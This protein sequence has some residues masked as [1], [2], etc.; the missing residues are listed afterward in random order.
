MLTP[1]PTQISGARFL[2]QRRFALLADLPRVG[3]TGSAIIAADAAM[4][5]RICVVTTASGRGVWRRGFGDWSNYGRKLQVLTGGVKLHDDT[6]VVIVSWGGLCQAGIRS[7]LLHREWDLVIADEAH[8]AKSFTTKR[9]QALYGVIDADGGL[10]TTI[11]LLGRTERMWALTGT[12]LPNCPLDAYPMMRALCPV[13]LTGAWWGF[14]APGVLKFPDVSFLDDFTKRYCRMRPMQ[15]GRGFYAKRIDVFVEGLNLEEL[16]ARLAGFYLQ[17]TQQDV[18]ILEPE[19]E[20]MPLDGEAAGFQLSAAEFSVDRRQVLDAA[21]AGDTKSLNMHLGPLRRLTGEIKAH[22]VV[23][24][25]KEE[26][27]AGLDK[28]V[29]AYWHKDVGQIL[30]DG[31]HKFGV[32]GIDGATSARNRDAA[33]KHFRNDPKVR[34]FLG[35]IQAAGEAIDLS[36]A[37]HL[38]FVETSFT[39]KDML[40]M[41]LR[42]T[43]HTQTQRPLVR[44]AT[45]EGSIDDA[46]QQIL[47][48]K[49]TAIKEVL[50]K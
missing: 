4:A 13:R 12:P 1:K 49:W 42:V 32:V 17:R 48:R 28:V 47:M 6:E 43:N 18:G 10:D 46:L 23:E 29:L 9:T 34:V 2:A 19:Y 21:K 40:Q 24:A 16:R 11:A 50:A 30:R 14:S 25:V 37:K 27:D 33:E 38:I 22:A 20:T 7:Q 31:L 41:S 8:A 45:L 39:P 3:K 15:I 5:Q 36:S 44:V 26:F 35:Q